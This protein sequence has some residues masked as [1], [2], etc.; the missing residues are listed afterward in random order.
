[1]YFCYGQY[2]CYNQLID[3]KTPIRKS[4]FPIWNCLSHFYDLLHYQSRGEWW[5]N[6]KIF[7][8]FEM[9]PLCLCTFSRFISCFKK[10]P[11]EFLT[12]LSNVCDC[13][14]QQIMENDTGFIMEGRE[15]N[16]SWKMRQSIKEKEKRK[17]SFYEKVK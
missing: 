10:E 11:C 1:M 4:A 12:C 6:V 17:R 14:H 8:R 15:I 5:N 9:I 16:R 3:L 7:S 13:Q 2:S